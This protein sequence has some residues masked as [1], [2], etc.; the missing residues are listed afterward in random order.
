MC[1]AGLVRGP[2][3]ADGTFPVA[4][5][6]A[7]AGRRWRRWRR[8]RWRR[9]GEEQVGAA[10]LAVPVYTTSAVGSASASADPVPQRAGPVGPGHPVGGGRAPDAD[11]GALGDHR[12][13]GG[14]PGAVDASPGTGPLRGPSTWPGV[15]LVPVG[16]FVVKVPAGGFV[17]ELS[18]GW[19]LAVEDA[20][21]FR[22]S[23]APFPPCHPRCR[24]CLRLEAHRPTPTSASM[25]PTDLVSMAAEATTVNFGGGPGDAAD[26]PQPP[27][28]CQA[29]VEVNG[30]RDS[31]RGD[32]VQVPE[33]SRGGVLK[34][35]GPER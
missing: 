35:L 33:S 31:L 23:R 4:D 6:A 22:P 10:A 29:R 17:V 8:R 26:V 18:P 28:R 19:G 15:E 16:G 5:G 7:A 30:H 2:A 1:P 21:G 24:R 3:R 27:V 13:G 20:I 9:G 32:G 11:N 14:V 12:L 25:P 34:V